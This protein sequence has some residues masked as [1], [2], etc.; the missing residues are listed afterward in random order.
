M[1][2][3]L[4]VLLDSRE[5]GRVSRNNKGQLLFVYN[6]AWRNDANA[7]PISLSMPLSSGEYGH[8]KINAFLWGYFRTMKLFSAGGLNDFRY[9]RRAHLG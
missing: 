3:E 6:E 1:T 5:V 2:K 8:G 4:I 7:Y 9:P